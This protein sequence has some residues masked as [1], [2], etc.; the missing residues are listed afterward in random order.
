LE[1]FPVT[2][3][4]KA[5]RDP[6]RITRYDIVAE[7]ERMAPY[8][9]WS[10]G[11]MKSTLGVD[12]AD[13]VALIREYDAIQV[14]RSEA[15]VTIT[16]YEMQDDNGARVMIPVEKHMALKN[17][18]TLPRYLRMLYWMYYKTEYPTAPLDALEVGCALRASGKLVEKDDD[19]V[20]AADNIFRYESWASEENQT[21]YFESLPTK[22]I[23]RMML[24]Q[25]KIIIKY[26]KERDRAEEQV[27]DTRRATR[28]RSGTSWKEALSIEEKGENNG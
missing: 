15:E 16:H 9:F 20:T 27:T 19:I 22:D 7:A 6:F 12:H 17:F 14:L 3:E 28:M 13:A 25:A 26:A 23:V 24:K 21:A 11:H 1:E 8:R 10:L 18:R 5:R 4:E 2:E